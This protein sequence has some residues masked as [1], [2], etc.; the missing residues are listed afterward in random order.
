VLFNEF[1][2]PWPFRKR[3]GEL[4][5]EISL[6]KR[7]QSFI[8]IYAAAFFEKIQN[9]FSSLKLGIE[10]ERNVFI[11][12]FSQNQ[13][14]LSLQASYEKIKNKIWGVPLQVEIKPANQP[15]QGAELFAAPE[16]VL[17]LSRLK[18]DRA[19]EP[20]LDPDT[21]AFFF[22]SSYASENAAFHKCICYIG[23]FLSKR[24]GKNP[25]SLASSAA[26]RSAIE[27]EKDFSTFL[28]AHQSSS[29]EERKAALHA[30]VEDVLLKIKHL[31][32]N[33]NYLHF[34]KI[35]TVKSSNSFSF[36]DS[37]VGSQFSPEA[38]RWLNKDSSEIVKAL[39]ARALG[40]M[41]KEGGTL[42][43]SLED[44]QKMYGAV[45]QVFEEAAAGLKNFSPAF[46]QRFVDSLK[47]DAREIFLGEESDGAAMNRAQDL[48]ARISEEG[49]EKIL[50]QMATEWVGHSKKFLKGCEEELVG[51][52]TGNFPSSLLAAASHFGIDFKQEPRFWIEITKRKKE[53]TLRLF[54]ND[55]TGNIHPLAA[56]DTREGRHLP[57]LFRGI[58]LEKLDHDFFYRLFSY[59]LPPSWNQIDYS[60]S[61][62]YD[63]LTLVLQKKEPEDPTQSTVYSSNTPLNHHPLSWMRLYLYHHLHL[64]EAS[65][66]QLFD[67]ELPLEMLIDVWP[68]HDLEVLKNHP[69]LQKTLRKTLHVL[70]ERAL[71]LYGQKKIPLEEL[72]VLQATLQEV[73]LV[74]DSIE[75]PA[76]PKEPEA[77]TALIIPPQIQELINQFLAE[78]EM[79]SCRI[80]TLKDFLMA[81]LGDEFQET[82]DTLFEEIKTF[83]PEKI[84]KKEVKPAL[85]LQKTPWKETLTLAYM[86]SQIAKLLP[87]RISLLH[88]YKTY[89]SIS[90]ALGLVIHLLAQAKLLEVLFFCHLPLPVGFL[91]EAT[92]SRL[93]VFFGP[94][95]V[96]HV[97]PQE[98]LSAIQEALAPLNACLGLV[99]SVVQYVVERIC[100][101]VA[102]ALIYRLVPEEELLL[103]RGRMKMMQQQLT[104]QGELDFHIQTK[105]DLA[106]PSMVESV[107]GA[108]EENKAS[109]SKVHL[110]DHSV[111]ASLDVLPRPSCTVLSS[112][113]LLDELE[114]WGI[115]AVF[116]LEE[117]AQEKFFY[118]NRQIRNLPIPGEAAGE[119]WTQHPK[120]LELLEALH[121]LLYHLYQLPAETR[122][123]STVVESI[124]SFYALYAIIHTLSRRIEFA[125][126]PP[127]AKANGRS[128]A[129]WL[130]SVGYRF[131]NVQTYRQLEHVAKYFEID[132][133]KKYDSQ[134][135]KAYE[136]NRL[137]YD[138]TPKCFW[139]D[140]EEYNLSFLEPKYAY[141]QALLADKT[142]EKRLAAYGLKEET[143]LYEKVMLLFQDP[144]LKEMIDQINKRPINLKLMQ[145]DQLEKEMISLSESPLDK[146]H[147]LLPRPFYF[148]RLVH[149]MAQAEIGLD[150][151][152]YKRG[153]FSSHPESE[154][155]RIRRLVRSKDKSFWGR[156]SECAEKAFH[157]ITF[158]RFHSSLLYS[159]ISLKE[160]KDFLNLTKAVINRRRSYEFLVKYYSVRFFLND[161]PLGKNWWDLWKVPQPSFR[162]DFFSIEPLEYSA[163][164]SRS[165]SSITLEPKEY[166]PYIYFE[167]NLEA[168]NS[169]L[170][171]ENRILEMIQIDSADQVIRTLSF[172]YQVK[173]RLRNPLFK[174]L[175][176][177][178]IGRL[179]ALHQQ[180][181]ERPSIVKDI[182]RYFVKMVDYFNAKEEWEVSLFLTQLSHEF[183]VYGQ[184]YDPNAADF[185]PSMKHLVQNL[186]APF[187]RSKYHFSRDMV[188]TKFSNGLLVAY[189]Y[190]VA[191]YLPLDP[192]EVAFDKKREIMHAIALM[193]YSLT[194]HRD[195]DLDLSVDFMQKSLSAFYLWKP[196]I[197]EAIRQDAS[198]REDLL[199]CL[200][201]DLSTS[202]KLCFEMNQ[203]SWTGEF[204]SYKKGEWSIELTGLSKKSS[205]PSEING[206]T[207]FLDVQKWFI[208][209]LKAEMIC[210]SNPLPSFFLSEIQHG[211]ALLSWFQ[212]LS[213]INVT[214]SLDGSGLISKIQ[215]SDL[216]LTYEVKRNKKE[217]LKAFDI[218]GKTPGFFL[219][220]IQ[221]DSCLI[222][223]GPYL[224]LENEKGEKKVHLIA[225][226]MQALLS[227]YFLKYLANVST[228]LWIENQIDQLWPKEEGERPT[229][230]TYSVG[231]DGGLQSSDP[232]ALCYLAL[233]FLS[234]GKIEKSL[235]YFEQVKDWGHLYPFPQKLQKQLD[236]FFLA[237]LA[238]QTSESEKYLLQLIVMEEENRILHQTAGKAGVINYFSYLRYLVTQVKY[239]NYLQNL[240]K[241]GY[242]YLSPYDELFILK[243][244]S[245]TALQLFSS[246]FSQRRKSDQTSKWIEALGVDRMASHLFMAPLIAKRYHFLRG[247]Y[248]KDDSWSALAEGLLLGQCFPKE[249]QLV[250]S[251]SINQTKDSS[252]YIQ[253]P[254][255]FT[256][257]LSKYQRAKDTP[258]SQGFPESSQVPSDPF[259]P[260][261]IE[262]L[263]LEVS[264]LTPSYL[265][266]HFL[267]FYRLIKNELPQG[268]EEDLEKKRL[269]ISK[270]EQMSKVF[271]LLQGHVHSSW[272]ALCFATLL[273]LASTSKTDELPSSN[274]LE[275]LYAKRKDQDAKEWQPTLRVIYTRA[276]MLATSSAI[277]NF[278]VGQGKAQWKWL[279]PPSIGILTS[280][281]KEVFLTTLGYRQLQKIYSLSCFALQIGASI[282]RQRKQYTLTHESQKELEQQTTPSLS[283]SLIE[284]ICLEEMKRREAEILSGMKAFLALYFE[285]F[286][287]PLM[288][289]SR[290]KFESVKG[291][292]E[293]EAGVREAFLKLNQ[294]LDDFYSRL[295]PAEHRFVLREE[296]NKKEAIQH[297]SALKKEVMK[298]LAVQ[299][300]EIVAFANQKVEK[301]MTEEE[302]IISSLKQEVLNQRTLSFEEIVDAFVQED[303]EPF[304]YFT[305]LTQENLSELKRKFYVYLVEASRW[306]F[307]FDRMNTLHLALEEGASW[308]E[309]EWNLFALELDRER[310]YSFDH[311]PEKIVLGKLIFEWKTKKLLWIKQAVQTERLLMSSHRHLVMELI[312]GAGKSWYVVPKSNFVAADGTA[313]VMDIWP[314]PL[315]NANI[316]TSGK[317]AKMIFGQS[318]S[319]LRISRK[320]RWTLEK[321]RGL[322]LIFE[323]IRSQKEQI[324]LSKESLQALELSFIEHGLDKDQMF[325]KQM[326]P[327]E[328]KQML[329]ELRGVLKIIRLHGIAFV[330]EAHAA[331][332]PHKELNFPLG[333]SKMLPSLYPMVMEEVF[334]QL[335]HSQE[336]KKVLT[337]QSKTP[338]RLSKDQFLEEIAPLLAEKMVQVPFLEIA[339]KDRNEVI[340]YLLG[341]AKK[342]PHCVLNGKK[343]EIALVKGLLT[344]LLPQALSNMIHVDY[345]V[346]K[347]GKEEQARPSEGNDNPLE[348]STIRSPYETF[349]KTA[350][351]LAR[352]RL[353][354]DQCDRL[355]QLL[356]RKASVRIFGVESPRLYV[357]YESLILRE[358]ML[359][360][361]TPEGKLF[362]KH[363][364]GYCLFTFKP[365]AK[366]E[367]H[368]LLN[369]SDRMV[370]RYL[371]WVISKEIRYFDKNLSSN[372]S[373]FTSM[374]KKTAG[375]TGSPFNPGVYLE[376]TH[377]LLDAGTDGE[378]AD[379]L[380]DPEK[381]SCEVLEKEAPWEVLEEI[382]EQDFEKNPLC[383]ALIERGALLNG[384]GSLEVANRLLQYISEKRPDLDG[385]AFYLN[386]DLVILEKGASAPVPIDQSTVAV[387]RR[388]SYY[389]EPQTYGAHIDQIEEA[390]GIVTVGE[391]L[392]FHELAQ[393]CWRM[394]GL[395]KHQKIKFRFTKE[396]QN[397]ILSGSPDVE[398]KIS[399]RGI[400]QYSLKNQGT[401]L[402]WD[403]YEAD[404][405]KL[406]NVGRR[407]V[408]DKVL[409]AP[410][411]TEAIEDVLKP[412]EEIFC[413]SVITDPFVL[414][415]FIDTFVSPSAI[416][417]E[418]RKETYQQIAK[419][420]FFSEQKKADLLAELNTHGKGIYPPLVHTYQ[421]N[422]HL[423]ITC[424]RDL[425]KSSQIERSAELEEHQETEKQIELDMQL[426]VNV[427]VQDQDLSFRLMPQVFFEWSSSLNPTQLDW[428]AVTGSSI[429]QDVSLW[430]L[431]NSYFLR[432]A[433]LT[434]SQEKTP[435]LFKLRDALC[436]A[437][438][439]IS[440]S[441]A[442]KVSSS[443]LTSNNVTYL[444][445]PNGYPIEPFGPGQIPILEA[446]LIKKGEESPLILLID[447]KEASYWRKKLQEDREG[448]HERDPTVSLALFDLSTRILAAEGYLSFPSEALVKPLFKRALMQILF[449]RGDV[450]FDEDLQDMLKAWI[451]PHVDQ[452]ASY[453]R[454]ISSHHGVSPFQDSQLEAIL[455]ELEQKKTKLLQEP[456]PVWA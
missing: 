141:Y 454:Y 36:F 339:E 236:G 456:T 241:G 55:T 230:F 95:I 109:P 286:S 210:S 176:S 97:I 208:K 8:S 326:K 252:E 206:S 299:K 44:L 128:L 101:K 408:L 50:E 198:F 253:K 314:A 148:L 390:V 123:L 145:I 425:N 384:L 160:P 89:A 133:L 10:Y 389:P 71:K 288:A 94:W 282:W 49:L 381:T 12:R 23:H 140:M 16:A 294:S 267:S 173:D 122:S 86:Q 429:K 303:D 369:I 348:D 372:S 143:P 398:K 34:G 45:H 193:A 366:S 266:R 63:W 150:F 179:P 195:K 386:Q 377:L 115:H 305:D 17:N 11:R 345:H 374:T 212:P 33:E 401:K 228:S 21:F 167:E 220:M 278:V 105:K 213:K 383:R 375:C 415:G 263:S 301:S 172:F 310:V 323:K 355:I 70:P 293:D 111:I 342:I 354:P 317:Q 107:K 37:L 449:L 340:F 28:S 270:A 203:T 334:F 112:E 358:K 290:K 88:L 254:S 411:I 225:Y 343:Q 320:D 262:L 158:H 335:I 450:A 349:V 327:S 352:N 170:K 40:A 245:S 445:A 75:P 51:E 189:H 423:E 202:E 257:I 90:Q 324:S 347:K 190:L 73:Q 83:V 85:E 319:A 453:A 378:T 325:S 402:P 272:E 344:I 108:N 174:F 136:E 79:T 407:A 20:R 126:I 424:L 144:P 379:L 289:R 177:A 427:N 135:L 274:K 329:D 330:D 192:K 428:L 151:I 259:A 199:N 268:W 80:D 388:L 43:G 217:D 439:N 64:D 154:G 246:Q 318:M 77:P 448:K 441:I 137:F 443:I 65:F 417:D 243:S 84:E 168:R 239:S 276:R 38:L 26:F 81:L 285:R 194:P 247:I 395:K 211:L 414:F 362:A 229:F 321:A 69:N 120:P 41:K 129:F 312:M 104:R 279:G 121:V 393:A 169:L 420:S 261:D 248:E 9:V 76:L 269:F 102:K 435:P 164:H 438:L 103:L 412:S 114:L 18:K 57:L 46:Y 265:A 216:D 116:F 92:L 155:L 196:H 291:V 118:L 152:G 283:M 226:G 237:L 222:S 364:P 3:V 125:H 370:L 182:G 380:L 66:S 275:S 175:L 258:F 165:Q 360:E 385:V 392:S 131:S 280:L 159:N 96:K 56:S 29:E 134:D 62:V 139:G 399:G 153:D 127:E 322:R 68:H 397:Q 35:P 357:G 434:S 209:E 387:E 306:N 146:R 235:S 365:E 15:L 287:I 82:F 215:F 328:W 371:T 313:F 147:G 410:T 205:I 59:Q 409:F 300:K 200:I 447:Q 98:A 119:I 284:P 157:S 264:D 124:T 433:D 315:L 452:F 14:V 446:L 363:C 221:K 337:I 431:S 6:E 100:L 341:K 292:H 333:K 260:S 404:G 22:N 351:F 250:S 74:L 142:V 201:L 149:L 53:C 48:W 184:G 346:S 214:P 297:I 130:Q 72:K 391:G 52:V 188:G 93:T 242:P 223:Y 219:S 232:E 30:V 422:G 359:L 416:F 455:L 277:Q 166:I 382:I 5:E 418:M 356:R 4:C 304:R 218:S 331:Y 295:S 204:P 187:Y 309:K 400:L 106:T 24:K 31:Q 403:D 373:N 430:R 281:T 7:R 249:N 67:Y 256:L 296:V 19:E 110:V 25:F 197:E 39:K 185:F 27:A 162:E 419:T 440:E 273:T 255:I 161:L 311:T 2:L 394:R 1:S 406:K 231:P 353:K 451:G 181:K 13:H 421:S 113:T 54:S 47:E 426:E 367:V 183:F 338:S 442:S 207:S 307:L 99:R 234:R 87:K 78:T 298:S 238:S 117:N 308:S 361:S 156:I 316:S 251:S 271:P 60:F 368:R 171:E 336:F 227:I 302:I 42:D 332:N 240:E 180:L 350:L 396:G 32:V 437:S 61:D 224:L 413:S 186:V 244:L 376:G 178:L 233:F 405:Q 444:V 432:R 191:S 163:K 138:L 436:A 91:S 132:L 58:S